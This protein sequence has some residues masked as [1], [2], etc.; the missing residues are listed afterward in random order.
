MIILLKS[1]KTLVITKDTRLYQGE[2]AVDKIIFYTPETYEDLDLSEFTVVLN[3][4]NAAQK[5]YNETLV[6]QESDKD[7]FLMYVLPVTTKFTELAGEIS[8]NLSILQQDEETGT[9]EVMH[10][11][12]VKKEIM[13]WDDYFKYY[14]NDSLSAID[15]RILELDNKAK[16]LKALADSIEDKTPDDLKLT[17][18]LL[19]LSKDGE[20]IG[21]GVNVVVPDGTNTDPIDPEPSTD[22]VDPNTDP[23]SDPSNDPT[24]PNSGT[25]PSDPNNNSDPSGD[26]T[27]DPSDPSGE[28]TNP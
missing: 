10:T 21:A 24:D 7:G 19:Q 26:P 8:M 27:T 12:S 11:N 1:N 23:S 2:N 3:Y 9:S 15:N 18:N 25:D 6:S 4:E 13:T 20:A 5:V 22:P 14:P 28:P 17:E 16:E